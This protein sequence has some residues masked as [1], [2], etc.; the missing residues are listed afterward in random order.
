MSGLVAP[1]GSL[2]RSVKEKYEKLRRDHEASRR[3][4]RLVTLA[5][6]RAER[7]EVPCSD[8][9]A[10]NAGSNQLRAGEPADAG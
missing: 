4:K 6:A 5:A 9:G 10:G 2:G 7:Y 8:A 1:D 3:E